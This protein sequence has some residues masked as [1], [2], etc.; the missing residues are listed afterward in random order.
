MVEIL[1]LRW[2]DR[3][4]FME[5]SGDVNRNNIFITELEGPVCFLNVLWNIIDLKVRIKFKVLL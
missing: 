2:M 4:G 5:M 1:L 3:V